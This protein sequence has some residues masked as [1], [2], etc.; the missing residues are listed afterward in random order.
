MAYNYKKAARLVRKAE[1][2]IAVHRFD[3]WQTD[4]LFKMNARRRAILRL[5]ALMMPFWKQEQDTQ[6]SDRFLHFGL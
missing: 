5:K 1:A 4:S 2:L 6:A 3:I